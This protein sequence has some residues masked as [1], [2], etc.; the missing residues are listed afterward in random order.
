MII[1]NVEVKLKSGPDWIEHW[2]HEWFKK[3]RVVLVSIP[4][5]F[6]PVCSSKQVPQFEVFFRDLT[7]YCDSVILTSVNDS[8]VME[9]WLKSIGVENIEWFP[10]GSGEFTRGM[11]MLVW[12]PN[13]N[14]G[15]RSWR[16]AAVVD[17]CKIEKMFAEEGINNLG[18][19][20]DPY[21]ESSPENVLSYLRR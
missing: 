12:K 4:G 13:Q 9:A 7:H 5:A 6:T 2:T 1:P 19:D 20:D 14:F 10:D 16:Y 15:Y 21:I 18:S 3:R 11:N 8:C 17:N